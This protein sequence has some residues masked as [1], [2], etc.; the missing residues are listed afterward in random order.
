MPETLEQ[1]AESLIKQRAQT[2]ALIAVLQTTLGADG[3]PILG[4]ERWQAFEDECRR[5]ESS[6]RSGKLP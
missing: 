2:A 1:L 5:Q 4:S 3:K 6:I